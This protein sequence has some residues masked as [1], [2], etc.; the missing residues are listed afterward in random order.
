MGFTS[1]IT[2]KPMRTYTR[3][4]AHTHT[5]TYAHTHTHAQEHTRAQTHTHTSTH[6]HTHTRARVS[7]MRRPSSGPQETRGTRTVTVCVSVCVRERVYLF[8]PNTIQTRIGYVRFLTEKIKAQMEQQWEDDQ[9]ATHK[10]RCV[11][12]TACACGKGCV[13][14]RVVRSAEQ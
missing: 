4:H 3:T 14:V 6:R 7:M 11:C 10:K 9:L 1:H 2:Y 8:L 13:R 5:H 12:C